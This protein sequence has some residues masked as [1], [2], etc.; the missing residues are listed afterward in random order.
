MTHAVFR[1]RIATAAALVP[2]MAG[3]ALAEGDITLGAAVFPESIAATPAG[4]LL[5][6]SIVQGT[7]FRAQPGAAAAEPWITG[8]GPTITGVFVNGDV[9]YVCSN[10]EFG[11]NVAALKT[12]DLA[13]GEETASFDFPDGGFCSDIA[14]SPSG[15]VYVTHLNFVEGQAGRLL[16]LTDAGLE[17]ILSDPAISGI[18]GIAFLGDSLIANNLLTDEL[19]RVELGADPVTLTPLAL[20]EPLDGPDG[21]RTTEDGT[22]LL[23]VE[24]YANRLVKVGIEGD[25][26]T[27]TVIAEGLDGPAGVAQIGDTAYV[28][29]GKFAMLGGDADPGVF[30]IRAFPLGE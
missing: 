14:V 10:G 19:Y 28:V 26:A 16:H 3:A 4:D 15:E 24:Q 29:E 25:A 11:S 5:V 21:M 20:S 18:D 8:I 1:Q 6:G 12:F 17:V 13:S 7:V 9:V 30:A 23:L 27:V 22:A 2:L